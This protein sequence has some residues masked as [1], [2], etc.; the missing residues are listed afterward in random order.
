M[1]TGVTSRGICDFG[2][3]FLHDDV[4][5]EKEEEEKVVGTW[6][7]GILIADGATPEP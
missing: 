4:D 2:I 1:A 7:S 6:V 3:L 5:G